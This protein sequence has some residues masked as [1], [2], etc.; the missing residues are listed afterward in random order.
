[1]NGQRNADRETLYRRLDEI[2]MTKANRNLAKAQLRATDGMLDMSVDA[3]GGIRSIAV[4]LKRAVHELAQRA[5]IER[6]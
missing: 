1:M 3:I 4:A 6:E 2:K 5:P